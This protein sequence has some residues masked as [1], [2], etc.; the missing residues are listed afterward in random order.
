MAAAR[1]PVDGTAA[2]RA[3]AKGSGE[4][5]DSTRRRPLAGSSGRAAGQGNGRIWPTRSVRG[6]VILFRLM[7]T[8]TVVPNRAAIAVSVSPART[9]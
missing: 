9:R 3:A 2:N 5:R 8:V 4:G 7:S 6:S 1:R